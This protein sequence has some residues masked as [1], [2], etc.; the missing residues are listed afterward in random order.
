MDSIDLGLPW[1]F[2]GPVVWAG[3]A[4]A[5]LGV[6]AHFL[7]GLGVATSAAN[8]RD[9]KIQIYYMGPIGWT[10]TVWA[11]GIVGMLAYWLMHHSAMS[12][13][14]KVDIQHVPDGQLSVG[15]LDNA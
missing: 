5:A 12:V 1:T 6:V 15:L 9:E 3:M 4:V 10:I 13:S 7:M 8:R 14:R 2:Y 11:T